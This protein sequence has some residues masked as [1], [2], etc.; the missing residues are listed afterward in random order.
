MDMGRRKEA[1]ELYLQ[2]T[3]ALEGSLGKRH[4]MVSQASQGIF[5]YMMASTYLIEIRASI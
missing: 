3:A 5:C 1:L 4:P 2:A